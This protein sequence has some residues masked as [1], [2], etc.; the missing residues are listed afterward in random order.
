MRKNPGRGQTGH[1]NFKGKE[2]KGI[3]EPEKEKKAAELTDQLQKAMQALKE[4]EEL[5]KQMAAQKEKEK[6]LLARL[7]AEKG[8]QTKNPPL[9]AIASPKDGTSVD[10]EYI[11]LLGVAEDDEGIV[12]FEVL[13]NQQPATRKDQRDLQLVAKNPKRIDFSERIRLREGK[14]DSLW[15]PRTRRDC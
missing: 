10:S 11:T 14:N 12:K 3:K 5:K 9:I 4:L 7:E 8:K 6:E 1:R 13:V 2:A 15:L